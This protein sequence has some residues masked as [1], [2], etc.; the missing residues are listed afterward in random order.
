MT[1]EEVI[2][3]LT[4]QRDLRLFGYEQGK[5][6]LSDFEKW[7]LAQADMYLKVIEWIESV[8]E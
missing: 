6:D 7:Q 4:E 3:F 2:A 5:D 1:K 8:K